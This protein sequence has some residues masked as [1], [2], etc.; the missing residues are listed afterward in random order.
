M[1][2]DVFFFALLCL[3]VKISDIVPP[4]SSFQTSQF[5]SQSA[6]NPLAM[7]ISP[8]TSQSNSRPVL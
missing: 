6:A 3:S 1:G 7:V 4:A 5:N 2:Y 8:Q